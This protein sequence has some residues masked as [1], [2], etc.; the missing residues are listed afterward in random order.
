MYHLPVT[1]VTLNGK[2]INLI[3]TIGAFFQFTDATGRE[4]ID[5]RSNEQKP[6]STQAA[7]N[8]LVDWL[9]CGQLQDNPK[10]K[11]EE[12]RDE[13]GKLTFAEMLALQGEVMAAL[14]PWLP[15]E[16]EPALQEVSG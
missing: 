9:Y 16:T 14:K 13:V 11:R 8:D 7:L 3:Y 10:L 2:T 6:R 5:F 4:L 12:V 15:A 1:A